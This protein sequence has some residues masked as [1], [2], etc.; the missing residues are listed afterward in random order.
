M[1][2]LEES[3]LILKTH[4][5]SP[6]M[7]ASLLLTGSCFL[8]AALPLASQTR[9]KITPHKPTAAAAKPGSE[10]ATLGKKIYDTHGCATC[11]AIAGKGGSS[12][13]DLT[14]TGSV[15]SHTPQWL[16]AQVANPKSHNP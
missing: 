2:T 11:H 1:N 10:M 13:P 12:G 9:K 4:L 7:A 3:A 16:S 14:S 5:V 8:I 15:P 6:M